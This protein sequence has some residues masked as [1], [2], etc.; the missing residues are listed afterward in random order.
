MDFI[1]SKKIN[2][3]VVKV[4]HSCMIYSQFIHWLNNIIYEAT[5]KTK[6]FPET[7]HRHVIFTSYDC[8]SLDIEI[9]FSFKVFAFVNTF[10]MCSNLVVMTEWICLRV[11]YTDANQ[12]TK[13]EFLAIT[14]NKNMRVDNE[15]G[16]YVANAVYSC[17]F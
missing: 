10:I 9:E 3:D 13:K 11:I 15:L 14:L 17:L 12:F 8:C 16:T 7:I 4:S 6:Q 5:K 1:F 2:A